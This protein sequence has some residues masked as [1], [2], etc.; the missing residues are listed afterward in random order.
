[1]RPM[2]SLSPFYKYNPSKLVYSVRRFFFITDTT[3]WFIVI[4]ILISLSLSKGIGPPRQFVPEVLGRT[5][6][7]WLSNFAVS[8]CLYFLGIYRFC[9]CL[10]F[11]Y[12]SFTF[13]CTRLGSLSADFDDFVAFVG[14]NGALNGTLFFIFKSDSSFCSFKYSTFFFFA[15]FPVTEK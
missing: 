14:L 6:V 1:M 5:S 15:T 4:W 9:C 11:T 12:G 3:W 10:S 2:L 7:K 8:L 13:Y